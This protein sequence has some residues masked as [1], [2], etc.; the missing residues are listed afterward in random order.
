MRYKYSILYKIL[1]F[2]FVLSF[3]IP[4]LS[5]SSQTFKLEF[6][7]NDFQLIERNG[8]VNI[9]SDKH[10]IF[11]E[12]NSNNPALPYIE[13][14][15]LIPKDAVLDS[16][17]F[18]INSQI[19]LGN[20]DIAPNIKISRK[21]LNKKSHENL[22]VNY[23]T[24][25]VYPQKQLP[26]FNLNVVDGYRIASASF[27]PFIYDAKTKKLSLI[28]SVDMT[29][30]TSKESRTIRNNVCLGKNMRNIVRNIIINSDQL[31]NL[32]PENI[33]P[34]KLYETID[35]LVVTADSLK[36]SFTKLIEWKR[37][38]G[39]SADIITTEEIDAT[40]TGN[41]IQEKIRECLYYY[42]VNHGL[43]Y[44]LLGGDNEIIP[45]VAF[46]IYM[47]DDDNFPTP[48]VTDSY[49]SNLGDEKGIED[50][51]ENNNGVIS[52]KEGENIKLNPNIFL[53]RIPFQKSEQITNYIENLLTYEQNYYSMLGFRE[54]LLFGGCEALFYDT[55]MGKS[56]VNIY[57]NI[58][59][60][61]EFVD[62]LEMNTTILYDTESNRI[63]KSFKTEDLQLLLSEGYNII[64]I[65]THGST[66]AW[67]TEDGIYDTHMASSLHSPSK[68]MIVTGAC[69][70]NDFTS[71]SI[72]LS[73][74]FLRNEHSGVIGYLGGT[75]AGIGNFS[76]LNENNI[77]LGPSALYSKLF[78]N[79][80]IEK[81]IKSMAEADACVKIQIRSSNPEYFGSSVYKWL[82]K[83]M[84][85]M[86][87]PEFPIYLPNTKTFDNVCLTLYDTEEVIVETGVEDSHFTFFSEFDNSGQVEYINFT[88]SCYGKQ[89]FQDENTTIICI[90]KNGYFPLIIG[91]NSNMPFK[92]LNIQKTI[93][94]KNLSFSVLNST[95][96]VNNNA[97]ETVVIT[98]G[99]SLE[100]KNI[101]NA[102]FINFVCE[103]GGSLSVSHDK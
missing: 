76:I 99:S 15:I 42:Y 2:A 44:A 81:G 58:I 23:D 95:I 26:N 37:L 91:K 85:V 102:E 74:A 45:G 100:L 65:D 7:E 101:K 47:F 33:S 8:K 64:N 54:K 30:T 1:L 63:N 80:I 89:L 56:D 19:E 86:G 55:I 43:T 29:I 73:E 17:Y 72:C 48:V 61:E 22:P 93:I 88:D 75:G 98:E 40:F 6:E 67:A 82:T 38:K 49:Y 3:N 79:N 57:G 50:L 18:E 20:F 24:T 66:D 60:E 90:T 77:Q 36:S 5:Q 68:S 96:G 94:H 10:D 62:K 11:F 103:K 46:Y 52:E 34:Y 59:N 39:L 13:T 71:D 51:D 69:Y 31:T 84:N 35:Y 12:Y 70:T 28:T 9:V 16:I 32:Y 14:N 41:N 53:S 83:S 21:S 25:I 27:S 78:Y 92:K 4:L 87:D 97:D